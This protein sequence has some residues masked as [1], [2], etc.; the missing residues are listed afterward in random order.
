[1]IHMRRRRYDAR[2]KQKF[3]DFMLLPKGRG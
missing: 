3:F 1:M 2:H